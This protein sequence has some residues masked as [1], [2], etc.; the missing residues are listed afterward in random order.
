MQKYLSTFVLSLKN[1]KIYKLD[2]YL[3]FISIP[4]ELIITFL[5]WK[6]LSIGN[7]QSVDAGAIVAYFLFLQVLQ[8]GYSPT[9]LVTFELWNEINNGTII[10]WLVRPVNYPIYMLVQKMAHF[11]M[12]TVVA[13]IVSIL[14]GAAF[15]YVISPVH[16]LY[17][18]IA[19]IFGNLLLF[20]LQFLIGCL[21]FWLKKVIAL[22]DV[23]FNILF[24]LG[25]TLL[26]IDMTPKIIQ[27]IA[28]FTPIPFV[29]FT[30]AKIY[31]GQFSLE[32]TVR[33]IAGQ[34]LWILILGVVI[35][36]VWK[37]GTSD[38]ITQGA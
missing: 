36:F 37:I 3:S 7:D 23:I 38:K 6:I 9:M 10:T 22:R 32:Q 19:S 8:L 24:I 1:A 35:N 18:M 34:L 21:T 30:P 25:G 13:L 5:F 31:A 17:G 4:I 16:L 2:F 33:N 20:E 27:D 14:I 26:P 28:Y 11:F 12:N 15:G 29:Y